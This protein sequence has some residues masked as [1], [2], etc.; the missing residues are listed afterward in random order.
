MKASLPFIRYLKIF[1]NA[2]FCFSSARRWVIII[3]RCRH[4]HFASCL[5]ACVPCKQR[6]LS[7][8]LITTLSLILM[9][10]ITRIASLSIIASGWRYDEAPYQAPLTYE[11]GRHAADGAYHAPS[12]A[13]RISLYFS[14][15]YFTFQIY[16]ARFTARTRYRA[17]LSAFIIDDLLPR[18]AAISLHTPCLI[19]LSFL[20][21]VA[22]SRIGPISPGKYF[23]RYSAR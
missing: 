4:M 20:L 19:S 15:A 7:A 9:S 10:D 18:F 11:N 1:Y 13:R 21:M 3:S 16:I 17:V 12:I 5:A 14:L 2:F 23:R 8:C 22:P 6:R